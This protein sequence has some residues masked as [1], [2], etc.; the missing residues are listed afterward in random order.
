MA[1]IPKEYY[2]QYAGKTPEQDILADTMSVPFQ[3]VKVFPENAKL[4][5]DE[6]HNMLIFGDNLQALKHLLKLKKEGKL[7]NPDGS[8]GVKLC[9]IDPPF[10]SE[11]DFKGSQDQ[12]AYYDKLFGAEFIEFLR[13]RIL[14][15]KELLTE[16][17]SLFLHIDYRKGHYIKIICDEIFGENNLVNEIIW[18]FRTYQGQVK[19]YF[20]KKHHFIFWYKKNLQPKFKLQY[21]ENFE[22]TVDYK[23]WKDYIIN[24]NEIRANNYPK[25]DSRFMAY[26]DRWVEDN[27]REPRK[28]EVIYKVQGYVI[29]DVWD[30]QQVDPKDKNER[31]DYASGTQKPEL[32]LNRVIYTCSNEG[33]IILDCFA[34]TGTTCAVAEKICN[35]NGKIAPRKWIACDIGKLSIYTITKRMLNLKGE[36]GNKGKSLKPKPFVL[37][38]AGL[39]DYELIKKMGEEDYK[40]FCLELFQCVPDNQEVNGFEMDGI[41]DNAPVLVFKGKYLT[42]EFIKSLHETVGKNLPKKMFIIA[43]DASVKFFEDWIEE[44]GIKYYILR[45]PYSII[46]EIEKQKFTSLKQPNSVSLLNDIVESVGFDFIEPPEVEAEYSITKPKNKLAEFAQIKIK[47]FKSNQRSKTEKTVPD[48]EALSMVL[49]DSNY[50][51][52]NFKLTDKFFKDEL[53]ENLIQFDP[54]I[55]NKVAI[56]Y[57]DIYGNEKFEVIEKSKFKKI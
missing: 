54:E 10:A 53:E 39:Y 19:N 8:D 12:K 13:K 31:I 34:G 9:Y 30:I 6:W 46:D 47:K 7:K 23:R 17:G 2:L 48:E 29:D 43:P 57:I 50:D 26:Y 14:L 33:D 22:E 45:I 56:T 21:L 51:G 36:I 55:G 24:G 15:I 49:I 3:P 27:G 11:Q 5:E 52:E 1:D 4:K 16:D 28:D 37:Y 38:N 44:D 40:K 25:T 20:P 35:E 41:K 18:R 32:L 42:H